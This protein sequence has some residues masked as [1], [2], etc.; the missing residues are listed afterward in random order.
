MI[1]T[2][3]GDRPRREE[4][5]MPGRVFQQLRRVAGLLGVDRGQLA[6]RILE[7]E[8]TKLEADAKGK[9]NDTPA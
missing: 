6:A 5:L 7:A 8:L 1:D 3:P 4:L 2:S 9:T